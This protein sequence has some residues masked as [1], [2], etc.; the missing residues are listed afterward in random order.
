M[1]TA[2]AFPTA[3]L[4]RANDKRAILVHAICSVL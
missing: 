1:L 4:L 2:F 3:L